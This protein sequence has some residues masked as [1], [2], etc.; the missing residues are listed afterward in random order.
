M[1]DLDV[2]LAEVLTGLDGGVA[3]ELLQRRLERIHRWRWCASHSAVL[4]DFHGRW[5]SGTRHGC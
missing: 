2:A 3:H 4:D 5:H 1:A